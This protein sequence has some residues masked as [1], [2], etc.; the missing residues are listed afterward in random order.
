MRAL[1]PIVP[2]IINVPWTNVRHILKVGDSI[3]LVTIILYD[4][5]LT[6]SLMFQ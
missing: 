6:L 4:T 2:I 1:A 5:G 3:S